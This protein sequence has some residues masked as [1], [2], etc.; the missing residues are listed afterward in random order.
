MTLMEYI[1]KEERGYLLPFMGAV[2]PNLL[3][4]KMEDIYLSPD[5]QLEVAEYMDKNFP[6]DFIYP[7]DDGSIFCDVLGVSMKKPD[8]DFP[9]V[10]THPVKTEEDILKLKK[11]ILSEER[12]LLNIETIKKI[13]Q[14]K[15]PIYVSIQGPFTLAVQLAGATHFLKSTIKNPE[16]AENLLKYTGELVKSY[17]KE[18]CEAGVSL[19]SIAEPSSVMISSRQF[20]KYVLKNLEDIFSEVDCWKIVHICG[21]TRKIYPQIMTL[22]IDGF[23]FDQIMDLSKISDEFPKDK[24][25]I[26]N[27]DPIELLGKGS[28]TEIK[29]EIDRL[30]D[31]MDDNFLLS[32]G[33]SAVNNTPAENLKLICN[34]KRR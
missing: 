23:S 15:K 19:I 3:K 26:G 25:I 9:M 29:N 18:L 34:Y 21:D 20:K 16:Y 24:V 12:V 17:V 7:L 32:F 28:S 13:K 4:L 1:N 2:G 31:L 8:Y 33:C 11:N 14:L 22:D 6:S 27:L 10:M 30:D 5:L